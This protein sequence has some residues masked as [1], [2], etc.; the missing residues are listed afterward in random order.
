MLKLFRRTKKGNYFLRGTI[1]GKSVYES[2]GV[3]GYAAANTIRQ[4][5][6]T[7]L[8]HRHTAG[9]GAALT[10]AEAALTYLSTGGE[11]RFLA[12]ILQHF[13]VDTLLADID[14]AALTRAAAR[15][16]PN[17][18]PATINRQL[19]T[20]V[21][22]V[23]TMAANEGHTQQRKFRRHKDDKPRTR[24]LSPE[25]FERLI[26]NASDHLRPILA[27]LVGGG[28]R[29]SEALGIEAQYYHPAT[30]EIWLPDVKNNHPRMIR[31]PAR[32]IDMM[33]GAQ[34]PDVGPIFLT[35]KGK[36]YRLR[37]NSGGQISVAFNKARAAANLGEEVTPHT[38]RHTWA[39]WY[40]AA[41]RDFG[42][43]LDI[44]G[45]QKSD[46][47]QRYRKIAPAD[48]P[49]RLQAHGWDFTALDRR[50]GTAPKTATPKLHSVK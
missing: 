47:A 43:L 39:T 42:G 19:I 27:C 49:D 37:K 8:M 29:T 33:Q 4:R 11:G 40:Y 25:E 1:A 35:P 21:S 13:G 28:F 48:L 5:R 20:P 12:N 14:N 46:M 36:P 22:A 32:S 24:W 44:G 3:N 23:V 45:W 34:M 9:T 17:A 41:T 31:L 7:E 10:F 50:T 2:T 26:D 18:R 30:G 16:Y 38:L 15:L 6:E